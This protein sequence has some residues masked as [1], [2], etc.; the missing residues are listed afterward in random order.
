ME[1]LSNVLSQIIESKNFINSTIEV[2]FSK[3]ISVLEMA[4]IMKK[5]ICSESKINLQVWGRLS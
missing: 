3:S 1:D 4:N 2:T 5:A